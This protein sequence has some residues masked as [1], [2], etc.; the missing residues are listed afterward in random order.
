[1]E[2]SNLGHTS[3]AALFASMTLVGCL[4]IG[5][6]LDPVPAEGSAAPNGGS[7]EG[8]EMGLDQ[9]L[10]AALQSNHPRPASKFA[11]AMAE[12]QHRQALSG[13]W[14]Q[15]TARGGYQ[16]MDEAPSLRTPEPCPPTP[17][18]ACLP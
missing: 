7:P 18:C 5:A 3:R 13:Y 17:T 11:V 9:C 6:D 16:R 8:L 1:M 4:A 10:R 2:R 15:L 14:L 12:A